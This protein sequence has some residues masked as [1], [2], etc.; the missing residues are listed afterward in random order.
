M[1]TV[2]N[3][4]ESSTPTSSGSKGSGSYGR[5]SNQDTDPDL[6]I[7]SLVEVQ[8]KFPLYGV[9]RW[10]GNTDEQSGKLIAGLE[11]VCYVNLLLTV[12]F[13]SFLRINWVFSIL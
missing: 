7:G 3:P 8:L 11:M 1:I 9:I 5:S 6:T 13:F 2:I 12:F 4:E 10:I